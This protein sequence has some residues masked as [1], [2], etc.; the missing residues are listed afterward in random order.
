[1]PAGNV[2]ECDPRGV[3]PAVRRGALGTFQHEAVALSPRE[4]RLYLTEDV[5]D[6]R[7]YRFTP[8]RWR[9]LSAG[10]LE[11]AIVSG[12]D[13]SW[14]VVPNP[15]P[16]IGV[17]T[18]TRQQVPGSAAFNGGEGITCRRDHVY[19][20]TKGDNRVWDLDT[21]NSRLT[22]FYDAALDPIMQLTGVDNVTHGRSGDLFVAED[23]G[24]MELVMLTP[25]GVVA[26]LLRVVGQDGSELA[27]PAFDPTGRRLYVSSQRG[28]GSG[29]TYEINGPFRRRA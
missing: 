17:D 24:N 13:V 2:W 14:A 10:T 23:G 27:G 15:N 4:R 22:V 21:R 8:T 12:Q 9:D 20:T 19:F 6:G 11:V 25:D 18:P 28:G 3:A 7:L 16:V 5:A 1:V 26:P 29:I